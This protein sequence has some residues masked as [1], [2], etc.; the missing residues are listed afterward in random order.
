MAARCVNITELNY[1]N[2]WYVVGDEVNHL[3][4]FHM[5]L[6]MG[7]IVALHVVAKEDSSYP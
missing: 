5:A 4:L 1:F 2:N 6:E 7:C 3:G